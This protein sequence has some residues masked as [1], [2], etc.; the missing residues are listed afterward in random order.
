MLWFEAKLENLFTIVKDH[1]SLSTSTGA[2]IV[3]SVEHFSQLIH[4]KLLNCSPLNNY[5]T[6]IRPKEVH[7]IQDDITSK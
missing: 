2:M 5:T 1:R 7:A 3:Q 6:L 4:Q